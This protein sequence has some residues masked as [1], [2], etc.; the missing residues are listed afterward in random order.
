MV[1]AVPQGWQQWGAKATP[2]AGGARG[3]CRHH[4]HRQRRLCGQGCLTGASGKWKD[5]N[6]PQ[7]LRSLG[8]RGGDKFPYLILLPRLIPCSP[9]AGPTQKSEGKRCQWFSPSRSAFCTQSRWGGRERSSEGQEEEVGIF[10]KPLN[11][12]WCKKRSIS[13]LLMQQQLCK[14]RREEVKGRETCWGDQV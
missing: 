4:Q 7:R 3:L 10:W 5:V 2:S 6:S 1:S 13:D 9:L 11:R 8:V 14:F 12:A